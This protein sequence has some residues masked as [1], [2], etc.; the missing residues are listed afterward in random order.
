MTAANGGNELS[1]LLVEWGDGTKTEA[2]ESARCEREITPRN[3]PASTH[4]RSPEH[5]WTAPGTYTAIVSVY[6]GGC[7]HF[8]DNA[9][10]RLR[11]VV[12][13]DPPKSS[14]SGS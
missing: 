8:A 7:D 6:V 4:R 5:T 14:S 9:T 1:Y 3:H 13:A 12:T 2:R 11:I 10:T